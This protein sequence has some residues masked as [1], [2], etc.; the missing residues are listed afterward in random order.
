MLTIRKALEK[1]DALCRSGELVVVS[2][3]NAGPSV[4]SISAR[5]GQGDWAKR[6]RAQILLDAETGIF[7]VDAVAF[8]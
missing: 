5:A 3:A 6:L 4:D 2:R 8:D 7:E 1:L